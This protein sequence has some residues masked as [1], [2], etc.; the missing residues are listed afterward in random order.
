MQKEV[1]HSLYSINANDKNSPV[2]FEF[3]YSDYNFLH[4]HDYFE[5]LIILNGS[6]INS[7][8]GEDLVGISNDAYLIRPNDLHK[9]ASNSKD[10]QHLN[11][12][13]T[14]DFFKTACE[15]ISKTLF[16]TIMELPNIHL[17]LNQAETNKLLSLLNDSKSSLVADNNMYYKILVSDLMYE[18]INQ[19]G[20]FKEKSPAWLS[21]IQKLLSSEQSLSLS[22]DDLVKSV[23]YSHTHLSRMF[24]E[25]TG[26]S[27]VK[28]I[29]E[30]K[31]DYAVKYLVYTNKSIAEIAEIIGYKEVS[32]F[33]HIFK[34]KYGITPLEYRKTQS[35]DKNYMN[36]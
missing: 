4:D 14:F 19:Y 30:V 23:N 10:A 21:E 17:K 2:D 26:I 5:L 32:H 33:N 6:Y 28:Y 7:I 20:L 15:N 29:Q 27:M 35:K 8:N 25:K 16:E 9:L 1:L 18:I 24:K 12:M 34:K 3:K 31:L 22:V 13:F 36:S 11:I